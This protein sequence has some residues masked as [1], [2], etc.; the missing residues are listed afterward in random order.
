MRCK[1]TTTTGDPFVLRIL[2]K[3]RRL[4]EAQP[5]LSGLFELCLDEALSP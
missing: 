3:M 4:A 5:A 2:D 1:T